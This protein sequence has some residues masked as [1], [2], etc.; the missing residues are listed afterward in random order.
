MIPITLQPEPAGFD[1][2]VRQPGIAWLTANGIAFAGRVP[3]NTEIPAHWRNCLDDLHSAYSGVCAYLC[4]FVSRTTGGASVDHFVAKS[5]LAG[6]AYEW[7]NFRLACS[8]LNSRK[9]EYADVMDPIG[10]AHETFHLNLLDF[11]IAPNPALVPAEKQLA[12]KTV[13]RLGLDTAWAR[14]ERSDLYNEYLAG[15]IDAD[16]LRRRSPFVWYEANRQG[17][18]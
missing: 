18:L 17:L 16:F 14:Y 4:I 9:R 1:A 11:S 13:K 12:E 2:A 3:A 5:A 10:L 15:H 8:R 7:S 6:D